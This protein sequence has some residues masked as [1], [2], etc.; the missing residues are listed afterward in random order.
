MNNITLTSW[1][2]LALLII[3]GLNWGFIA[4]LNIDLVSL[5]F[6]EMTVVSR[7]IYGAVALSG[8]YVLM[9][10]LI[11]TDTSTE[12]FFVPAVKTTSSI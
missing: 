6:G 1:V 10:A 11:S 8:I 9:V 3:G 12:Q 7:I 2:A 5:A 4:L